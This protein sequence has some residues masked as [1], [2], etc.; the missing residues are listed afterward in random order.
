MPLSR[1]LRLSRQQLRGWGR[2]QTAAL[3]SDLEL[4]AIFGRASEGQCK[5]QPDVGRRAQTKRPDIE[6][7]SMVS[8]QHSS[9]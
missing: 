6:E 5:T 4:E 7:Q 9:F 8:T 2:G 1:S 3:C